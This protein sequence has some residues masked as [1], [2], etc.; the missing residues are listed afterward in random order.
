[1]VRLDPNHNPILPSPPTSSARPRDFTAS[2]TEGDSTSDE[3]YPVALTSVAVAAVDYSN[4]GRLHNQRFEYRN[5]WQSDVALSAPLDYRCNST[6]A[7]KRKFSSPMAIMAPES[8]AITAGL[9]GFNEANGLRRLSKEP[10]EDPSRLLDEMRLKRVHRREFSFLP[11]DD[12]RNGHLK[13]LMSKPNPSPDRASTRLADRKEGKSERDVSAK[14]GPRPQLAKAIVPLSEVDNTRKLPHREG[15]GKSVLT[16]IKG[17]SSRSS[18]YSYQDSIGSND[19]VSSL[20][21][22]RK[23]LGD[24]NFAIAAARAARKRQAESEGTAND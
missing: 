2:S 20:T 24:N 3:E 21:G 8:T 23:G 5:D 7:Q 4:T 6:G 17:S 18:S 10:L 13:S 14:A 15:S 22:T 16:A 1:M 11:G 19:G 9:P 12:S